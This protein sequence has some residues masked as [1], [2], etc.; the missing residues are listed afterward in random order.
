MSLPPVVERELRV[1][2]RKQ[3]PARRRLNLA[4]GAACATVFLLFIGATRALHWLLFLFGLVIVLRSLRVT[5]GL[6]SEER[7]NQTLELLFLTGMTASQL[8]VTKLAGGFL[9]ASSDLLAIMPFLSIPFLAGG[10]SLELFLA[11]LATLPTLLLFV[12]GVGVLASVI[13]TED[14]TAMLTAAVI[15]AVLCCLTPLPYNLGLTLTNRAPFSSFWLCLSPA[16]AP[17]LVTENFGSVFPTNFWPAIGVTLGWSLLCFGA[18]AAILSFNWRNDP[19]Q[20][21]RFW[22]RTWQ[23]WIHGSDQWRRL[24][25]NRLLPENPFRWRIQQDRRPAVFAWMIVIGTI[26]LWLTGWFVWPHYWL[27]AGNSIATATVIIIALYWLEL[28]SAAQHIARE[29]RDGTLELLLTTPLAPDH[30]LDGLQ[31]A[32]A[33]QFRSTRRTAFVFFCFMAATGF[34]ARRW[35]PVA[36]AVHI[37]LWA[38]LCWFVITRPRNGMTS[39]A[40]V[41]LVSGRAGYALRRLHNLGYFWLIWMLFHIRLFAKAI[42]KSSTPFPEGTVTELVVFSLFGLFFLLGSLNRWGGNPLQNSIAV[43][44]RAIAQQPIPAPQDPRFRRWKDIRQPFPWS[45]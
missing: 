30:M 21:T 12:V 14:G 19:A 1:A 40:W 18:A 9:I 2:F 35:N 32:F 13:C 24:L 37:I 16:Y 25:R 44:M 22:Q 10:L 4:W 43:D 29:R 28:H 41:A 38:M 45:A 39:V 33:D 34:F 6:F 42:G 26:V 27:S 5:V 20:N 3:Q 31:D 11:T 23:S 17:W 15:M 7:R 36:V 8:F